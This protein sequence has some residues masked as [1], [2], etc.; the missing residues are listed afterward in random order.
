MY[1]RSLTIHELHSN[2]TMMNNIE[3]NF[4]KHSLTVRQF[5]IKKII[6]RINR[7]P[8]TETELILPKENERL[9][10][11]QGTTETRKRI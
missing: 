8:L 9:N 6:N 11:E 10:T 4:I 5:R 3:Y 1:V 2:D 7:E